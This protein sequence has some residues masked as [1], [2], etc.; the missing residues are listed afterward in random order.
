[1]KWA[2]ANRRGPRGAA[3]TGETAAVGVAV[4]VAAVPAEI[5]AGVDL[6]YP[7]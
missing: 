2:P 4:E 1:M 7:D 5:V 6:E 3:T